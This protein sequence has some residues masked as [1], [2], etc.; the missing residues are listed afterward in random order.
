MLPVLNEH[1][2]NVPTIDVQI[3]FLTQYLI[4]R[5]KRTRSGSL[6]NLNCAYERLKRTQRTYLPFSKSF[7]EYL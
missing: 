1:A 6:F 5:A 3:M 4:R 2:K 7:S